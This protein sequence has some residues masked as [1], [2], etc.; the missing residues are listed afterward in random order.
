M[1]RWKEMPPEEV[2]PPTPK[3]TTV[4]QNDPYAFSTNPPQLSIPSAAAQPS[5]VSASVSQNFGDLNDDDELDSLMFYVQSENQRMATRLTEFS[6][7]NSDLL[8][9]K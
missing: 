9:L 3:P 6:Q 8:K 5:T 4:K 1:Q 7:F 2:A